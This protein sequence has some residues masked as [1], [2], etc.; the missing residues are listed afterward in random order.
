MVNCLFFKNSQ[1]ILS[2]IKQIYFLERKNQK[3]NPDET[4]KT[5]G[6]AKDDEEASTS[7]SDQVQEAET[8][9]G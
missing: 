5:D 9:N 2:T 8:V 3:Q 4:S 1:Q 6:T 7:T